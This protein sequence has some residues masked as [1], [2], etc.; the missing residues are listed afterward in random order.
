MIHQ[1]YS[2]QVKLL[3]DEDDER[4]RKRRI[5]IYH[6]LLATADSHQGWYQTNEMW[7]RIVNN[8]VMAEIRL[9]QLDKDMNEGDVSLEQYARV[10]NGLNR[11]INSALD[12]L[13]I[14]ASMINKLTPKKRR[15]KT[16]REKMD[17]ESNGDMSEFTSS[18]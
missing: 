7:D 4:E 2:Y 1:I 13:G 3:N 10:S 9:E 14:S 17:A 18:S 15:R 8:L 16:M 11:R 12:R 6:K 5:Q